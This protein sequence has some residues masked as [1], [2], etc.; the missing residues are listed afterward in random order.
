MKRALAAVTSLRCIAALCLAAAF[1]TAFPSAQVRVIQILGATAGGTGISS[2]VIG[3]LLYASS[4]T[5]LS[6][7]AA[8]AAGRVLCSAGVAPCGSG[9][10]P[11]PHGATRCRDRWR[12]MPGLERPT[13]ASAAC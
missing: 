2:Y 6:K 4:S 5:A 8:T 10:E 9:C 7:L 12:S 3:D 13:R 11:L 1:F